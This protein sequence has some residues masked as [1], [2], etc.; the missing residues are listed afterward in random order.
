M[1]K[2]GIFIFAW[3]W[4]IMVY[5]TYIRLFVLRKYKSLIEKMSIDR[6]LLFVPE[7]SPLNEL[8][9]ADNPDMKKIYRIIHR[10]KIIFWAGFISYIVIITADWLV[11]IIFR[12]N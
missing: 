5:S 4:C 8:K 1:E 10:Y 6:L 11:S 12:Q 3:G 7:I 9:N 2:F